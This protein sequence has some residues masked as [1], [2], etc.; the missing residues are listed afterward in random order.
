MSFK[1]GDEVQIIGYDQTRGRDAFFSTEMLELIG[2]VG[3]IVEAYV[4]PG[5][6]VYYTVEMVGS[7]DCW[8]WYEGD[9]APASQAFLVSG[10]GTVVLRPRR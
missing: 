1:I 3:R 10:I 8:S 2:K 9:L 6:P 7:Y 4:R 5:R